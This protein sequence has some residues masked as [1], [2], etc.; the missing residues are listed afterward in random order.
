MYLSCELEV[1]KDHWEE[2]LHLSQT[3][4]TTIPPSNFHCPHGFTSSLRTLGF[5][6][7]FCKVAMTI[8]VSTK[9]GE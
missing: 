7:L 5:S 9:W 4:W 1:E 6:I 2:Y 8:M 3:A